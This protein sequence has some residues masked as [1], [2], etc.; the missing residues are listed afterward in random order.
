MCCNVFVLCIVGVVEMCAVEIWCC[1]TG[2]ELLCSELL[3]SELLCSEF[4][5]ESFCS[6]VKDGNRS[7][8]DVNLSASEEIESTPDVTRCTPKTGVSN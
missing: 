4:F 7:A 8:P 5:S 3:C 1:D 6:S 2:E